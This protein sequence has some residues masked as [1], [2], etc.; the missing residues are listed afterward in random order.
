ME[1][2]NKISEDL[3]PTPTKS[4]YLF[5]L[6]D[7]S[8]VFQGLVMVKALHV[9]K[10]DQFARLWLHESQRVFSDRL[11]NYDDKDWCSE[12]TLPIQQYNGWE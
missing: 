6:R 5:N 10:A 11:I 2:Y 9:N 7:V 4:H 1:I 3:L 12:G 8:K